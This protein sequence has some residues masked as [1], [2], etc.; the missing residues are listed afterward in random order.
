MAEVSL[1]GKRERIR[2]ARCSRDREV[3]LT[4]E[5]RLVARH[6]IGAGGRELYRVSRVQFALSLGHLKTWLLNDQR[7]AFGDLIE[8]CLSQAHTGRKS[9]GR[10]SRGSLSACFGGPIPG[11]RHLRRSLC[12]T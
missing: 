7:V 4:R 1:V 9:A 3:D 2:I 12:L 8:H 6:T 5:T 11:D 10:K